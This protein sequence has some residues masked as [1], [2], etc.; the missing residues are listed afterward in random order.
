M[1][2][3]MRDATCPITAEAAHTGGGETYLNWLKK[4]KPPVPQFPLAEPAAFMQCQNLK[5]FSIVLP[6]N[7]MVNS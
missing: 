4:L 2:S 5:P 7:I 1:Q 6:Y 3:K